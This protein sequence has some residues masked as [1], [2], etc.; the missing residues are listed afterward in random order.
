VIVALLQLP[1]APGRELEAGVQACREAAARGADVA[2]FPELWQVGYALDA[3]GIGERATDLDGEFAGAFRALAR[4]LGMAI[5]VTYLQRSDAGPRNAATVIDRRGE[6]VL[7]YAKVHTCDFSLEAALAPGE[8]FA[9]ADLELAGGERVRIGVMICYDREFP[10]SARALMLAGAELIL[11][12]NACPLNDDRVGQFRARAFENMVGVAMANYAAPTFDG[13][14]VAFS[15][16]C[17]A[18]DGAPLDHTL[19][20]A[21]PQEG[22]FLADFDLAALRAYRA[23]ETLGDAYRKPGA[24]ASLVADAPAPPFG[25]ADSRRGPVAH[26]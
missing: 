4:E 2:L 20:E 17:C 25:R 19:V 18:P 5:V 7:T 9:A 13:R 14:S 24:Y 6:P 21:G 15:G 12:P 8:R 22:I 26:G 10:E 23:R 3:P 1:A 16:I 11:T